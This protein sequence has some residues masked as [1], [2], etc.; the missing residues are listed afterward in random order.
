[1]AVLILD[2]FVTQEVVISTPEGR[3]IV[4]TL[5]EARTPGRAKIGFKA[6]PDVVIDRREIHE[7][8]KRAAGAA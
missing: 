2:R 8:K 6:D 3:E 1:M 7:L 4:V 5:A